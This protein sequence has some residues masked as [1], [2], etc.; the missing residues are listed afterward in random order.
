MAS[1]DH[2]PTSVKLRG[3][4]RPQKLVLGKENVTI[5]EMIQPDLQCPG[6]LWTPLSYESN[7]VP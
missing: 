6:I 1:N 3:S 5:V 4:R 7:R 2:N